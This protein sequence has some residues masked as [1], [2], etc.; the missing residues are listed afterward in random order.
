MSA[1]NTDMKGRWRNVTI[2]FRVTPEEAAKIDMLAKTSGLTKQDYIT[3]RLMCLEVV[4]HPNCRIQ[5]Y[6]SQYLVELTEELKR[7]QHIEQDDDTLL[8]FMFPSTK[9]NGKT[10]ESIWKKDFKTATSKTWMMIGAANLATYNSNAA[11][12][13]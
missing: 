5:K 2:A 13:A 4:I 11:S 1:K 7:L 10:I 9:M 12:A 6:L 3:N 8:C